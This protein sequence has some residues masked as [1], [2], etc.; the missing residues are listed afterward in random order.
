[1]DPRSESVGSA[2]DVVETDQEMVPRVLHE[3]K[4]EDN[5][6]PMLRVGMPSMALCVVCIPCRMEETR[7]VEEGIP[8]RSVGTSSSL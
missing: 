6:L 3:G 7:S 1:M 8:T 5:F 4:R 2:A